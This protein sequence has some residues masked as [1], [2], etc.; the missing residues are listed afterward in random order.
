MG[1]DHAKPKIVSVK[2][3]NPK[4][5]EFCTENSRGH[6]ITLLAKG[7]NAALGQ[8]RSFLT[9]ALHEHFQER[10]YGHE[11]HK[12]PD[13]LQYGSP[14]P[15]GKILSLS[16]LGGSRHHEAALPPFDAASRNPELLA[17]SFHGFALKQ[18]QNRGCLLVTRESRIPMVRG[19]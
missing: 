8:E 6:R 16:K 3:G 17:H 15:R 7:V 2:V 11:G 13:P 1:T 4:G 9:A 10:D 5:A 14:V 19:S 12:Q 18:A